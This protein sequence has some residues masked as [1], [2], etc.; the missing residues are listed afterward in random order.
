MILKQWLFLCRTFILK[1]KIMKIL[2]SLLIT[3][4]LVSC[5]NQGKYDMQ[6]AKQATIDSMKVELQKQ[7]VIDSMQGEMAANR[8][9]ERIETHTYTTTSE[10]AATLPQETKRKGWSGAAKGAVIGAGVGA[11]TG[12]ITSKK[13]GA[14]AIIGGLVG[15]GVGAGTGA[16]IDDSKKKKE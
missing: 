14:G 4:A 13:K 15:A 8:Q 7:K 9:I 10:N 2:Y 16:I 5:Q 1:F 3:L 11:A 12:A 6:L